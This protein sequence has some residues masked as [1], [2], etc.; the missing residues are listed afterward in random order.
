VL[1]W[2]LRHVYYPCMRTGMAKH[3]AGVVVF[4]VSA[5]FHELLVGLPLHMLRAWSFIG[6]MSQVSHAQCMWTQCHTVH[7]I[8]GLTQGLTQSRG[9]Q[10][11]PAAAQCLL[12][13]NL[14]GRRDTAVGHA[15]CSSESF[16]VRLGAADVRD[17]LP[18]QAHEE[19][20]CRQP[21]VLV[22]LLRRRPAACVHPGGVQYLA[23]AVHRLLMVLTDLEPC[24]L[25]HHQ[26]D[27]IADQGSPFASCAAAVLHHVGRIPFPGKEPLTTSAPVG[28]D[29]NRQSGLTVAFTKVDEGII[30]ALVFLIPMCLLQ[31]LLIPMRLCSP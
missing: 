28:W 14:S 3:V 21:G 5:V 9:R 22:H 30:S 10:H 29:V 8:T 17:G 6:I 25:L 11:L 4:L 13:S 27:C 24:K 7:T 16:L 12:T 31:L 26:C 18:A 19:R 20:V 15:T 2:L 23:V 1:Q